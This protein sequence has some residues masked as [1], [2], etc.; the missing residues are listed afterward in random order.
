ME[1]N[2]TTVNSDQLPNDTSKLV[3][4]FSCGRKDSVR[5]GQIGCYGMIDY[6]D[7]FGGHSYVCSSFEEASC[8]TKIPACVTGVGEVSAYYSQ[9]ELSN[10]STRVVNSIAKN[11]NI[12]PTAVREEI[13]GLWEYKC[14][15]HD[16]E[17]LIS[18]EKR[19]TVIVDK[20]KA[21]EDDRVSSN[22]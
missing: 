3:N 13:D 9:K 1:S 10:A 7:G 11:M 14:I 21:T 20:T 8:Q 12:T 5:S 22:V 6:D 19:N 4:E 16:K 2:P 15:Q 18:E 17:Q